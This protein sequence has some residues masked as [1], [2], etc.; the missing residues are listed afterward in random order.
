MRDIL[1]EKSDEYFDISFED[2]DFKLTEGLDTSIIM[3]LLVDIRAEASEVTEPSLRRGWIG[4]EQNDD[5]DHE[6]GSK[7]WLLE[8]ARNNQNSINRGISSATECFQWFLTDEIAKDVNVSGESTSSDKIELNVVFTRF[9]NSVL[10]IQFDLW[11]N[12]IFF[13]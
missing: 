13:N 8:Q 12:T 3:S 7:L 6:V 10:N 11:E 4:N 2:G 5:P 1:L 9:N